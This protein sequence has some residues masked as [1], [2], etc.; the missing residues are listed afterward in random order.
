[1]EASSSVS[2]VFTG[3]AV[4]WIGY[5]D[6][7]SGIAEVRLDRRPSLTVDTYSSRVVARAAL[8]TIEGLPRGTHTLTIK[9]TGRHGPAS[10]GSWIWVDAFDYNGQP[11]Q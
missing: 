2:F 10:A 9:P 6:E 1:M 11:S 8:Y 4:S 3:T 5:R 7:W